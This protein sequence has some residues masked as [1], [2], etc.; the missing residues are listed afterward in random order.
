MLRITIQTTDEATGKEL[1][2][3]DTLRTQVQHVADYLAGNLQKLGKNFE[4]EAQ[5]RVLEQPANK[6]VVFL[7]LLGRHGAIKSH[8]IPEQALNNDVDLHRDLHR[9]LWDFCDILAI[10]VDLILERLRASRE[11]FA[12]ASEK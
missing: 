5:I 2:I 4:I 9:P 3:P 1:A 7:D 6:F 11:E 12:T 10:E 8:P